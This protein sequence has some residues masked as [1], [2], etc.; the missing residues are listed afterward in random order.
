VGGCQRDLQ[1]GGMLCKGVA[2]NGATPLA[3][4]MRHVWPFLRRQSFS[5]V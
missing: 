4:D 5:L 2:S 3:E 1:G